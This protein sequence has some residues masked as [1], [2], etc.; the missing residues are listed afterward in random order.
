MKQKK[1]LYIDMDGVLCDFDGAV[2]KHPLRNKYKNRKDCIPGIFKDLEPL[3]G[4]IEAFE[5]LWDVFDVYILSTPPWRN[6]DGWIHKREWVEKYIPKAKRR[7]ILTHH[8]NLNKGDYLI[9]DTHY[10]GQA[11]FDGQWIHFNTPDFP[12]WASV[13][14]Y[15]NDIVNNDE[16]VTSY[17][18]NAITEDLDKHIKKISDT[19]QD[20]QFKIN[21][22]VIEENIREIDKEQAAMYNAE[23]EKMNDMMDDLSKELKS[24]KNISQKLNTKK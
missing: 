14:L 4:A 11:D 6:P 2:D 12:D 8:K 15:F 9:D 19:S 24:L 1:I 18:E 13:L 17:N 22:A 21:D 5:Y 23:V 10:R 20:D 16:Q 7:L 3:P